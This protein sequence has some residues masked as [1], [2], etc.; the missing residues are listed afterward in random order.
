[1]VLAKFDDGTGLS[2]EVRISGGKEAR[3]NPLHCTKLTLEDGS[4]PSC[5][6]E[7]FGAKLVGD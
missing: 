7:D 1:M 3:E 5:P 6:K 2:V 4:T